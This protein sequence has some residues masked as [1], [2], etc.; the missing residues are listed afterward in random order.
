[1]IEWIAFFLIMGIPVVWLIVAG[2]A[3]DGAMQT[4]AGRAAGWFRVAST[5]LEVRSG[6]EALDE[7]HDALGDFWSAHD[8]V[9]ESVRMAFGIAAAE[10]FANIVEYSGAKTVRMD[11]AM[12]PNHLQVGFTDDGRP[13]E[14]DLES[15][16]M[17]DEFAESGRGLAIAKASLSGLSYEREVPGGNRWML[18]SKPFEGSRA[19]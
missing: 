15:V 8:R 9:P 17:P 6:P 10:V 13:V 3:S 18:V 16:E 11:V 4:E 19:A 5:E 2:G 1:M 7:I 14:V 12:S